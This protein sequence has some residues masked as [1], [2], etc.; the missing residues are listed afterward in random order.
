MPLRVLSQ[1]L[2]LFCCV[3]ENTHTHTKPF[4]KNIGKMGKII[5]LKLFLIVVNICKIYHFSVYSLSI[6]LG[7]HNHPSLQ[8]YLSQPNSLFIK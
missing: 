3:C 6:W 8:L 1:D 7:S 2:R 4:H 5:S